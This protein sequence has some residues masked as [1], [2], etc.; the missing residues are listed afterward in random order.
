MYKY[1]QWIP[2]ATQ[3]YHIEFIFIQKYFSVTGIL[4]YT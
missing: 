1:C 4:Q 2:D 3:V